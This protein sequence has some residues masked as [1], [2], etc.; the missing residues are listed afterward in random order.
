MEPSRRKQLIR[1]YVASWLTQDS[2]RFVSLLE[3][4]VHVAECDGKVIC[5]RDAC[6]RW[7]E[8]WHAKPSD[9]VVQAW[10]IW[11]IACH[12]PRSATV[13]WTFGCTCYGEISSFHGASVFEFSADRIRAIREYRMEVPTEDCRKQ[14]MPPS[15]RNDGK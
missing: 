3:E 8:T 13:E 14:R 4:D 10:D 9:G 11:H 1:T 5:G 15:E 2:K 12:E 7:F 6:Q